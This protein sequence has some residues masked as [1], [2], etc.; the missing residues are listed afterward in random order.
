[1]PAS[2]RSSCR[3][4]HST[5]RSRAASP[6]AAPPAAAPSPSP[7]PRTRKLSRRAAAARLDLLAGHRVAVGI[8]RAG[9]KWRIMATV[10][11]VEDEDQVRVLAESYLREQ[12]HQTVSAATAEEALPVFEVVARI[13]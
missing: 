9:G 11:I 10:L 3:S 13:D 6:T 2:V 1:M 7:I 5:C 4:P 12:G 8:L